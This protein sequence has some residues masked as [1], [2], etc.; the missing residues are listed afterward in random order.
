MPTAKGRFEIRRTPQA[1]VDL[2]GDAQAMH[3]RFDKRFEGDMDATSVVHML[4]AMT[5]VEGSA[6][7]VAIERVEGRLGERSGSFLL[8]HCGTMDRGAPT[9]DLQVVPDSADG[10]LEGLRGSMRID[11]VD[12]EHFYVF[13]YTMR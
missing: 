6:A 3:M 1:P 10:E 11:I 4:A 13:D 2:G 5:A 8:R 9:L 12:G 7:Y